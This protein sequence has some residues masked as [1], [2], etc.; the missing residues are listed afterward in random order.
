MQQ[1]QQPP[2][3]QQ[4]QQGQAGNQNAGSRTLSTSKRAEQNRKAQRAFRERRDQHVKA[5]ESRSQLL[6][7]ALASAD[8]ANRRWEECRALV[9]QLR[10]ENAA[11]RAAL[12]QA[13]LLPPNLNAPQAQ[14]QQE[15]PKKQDSSPENK[16]DGPDGAPDQQSLS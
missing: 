15:E 2:P 6:D 12:S 11:L 1:Q 7:A 13:Q 8:E 5:L 16:P 4:Q 3:S 14:Q 9:D 10:V